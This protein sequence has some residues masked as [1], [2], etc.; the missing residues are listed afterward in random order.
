M[1]RSPVRSE[2]QVR[3]LEL[4]FVQVT[5]AVNQ[6]QSSAGAVKVT[7]AGLSPAPV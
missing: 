6:T 5:G 7:T 2:G 1:Y 3:S 4:E